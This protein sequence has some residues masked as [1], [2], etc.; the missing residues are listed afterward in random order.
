MWQPLEAFKL[1][2]LVSAVISDLSKK[3]CKE[4][5]KL[6]AVHSCWEQHHRNE[7]SL[8]L[9]VSL[10]TPHLTCKKNPKKDRESGVYST[11][12]PHRVESFL[13]SAHRQRLHGLIKI[14]D[15][16]LKASHF[17]LLPVTS[18]QQLCKERF[19]C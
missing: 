5:V 2:G 17:F 1:Q 9:A 11:A 7:I 10:K 8:S 4:P 12:S 3:G 14:N 16:D 13:S 15:A 19:G 18:L 6:T